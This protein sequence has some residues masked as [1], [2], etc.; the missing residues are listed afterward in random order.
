MMIMLFISSLFLA[1]NQLLYVGK[2]AVAS[3]LLVVELLLNHVLLRFPGFA[4]RCQVPLDV[5][6]E[7][8]SETTFGADLVRDGVALLSPRRR[9]TA[10][11]ISNLR[12]NLM[13]LSSHCFELLQPLL[14]CRVVNT[15][16]TIVTEFPLQVCMCLLS[17]LLLLVELRMELL[18]SLPSSLQ[19]L[20]VVVG[21][22]AKHLLQVVDS[23][24]QSCV[25]G[26]TSCLVVDELLVAFLYSVH[27]AAAGLAVCQ[28]LVHAVDLVMSCGQLL[29]ML[30]C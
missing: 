28:A 6:L 22:V 1:R 7:R 11:L 13:V 4:L 15:P 29:G 12:Q 16:L 20:L 19:L 30:V 26:I 8:F 27:M 3:S 10:K 5:L 21:R 18:L 24:I 9:L 2:E 25:M 23:F 17:E 14:H